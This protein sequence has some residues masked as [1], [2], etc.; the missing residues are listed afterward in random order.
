MWFCDNKK[1]KSAEMDLQNQ[2]DALKK[3]N[4]SL[5]Y[6]ND[7]YKSRLETEMNSASFVIDW[8]TMNVFSVERMWSNGLHKTII[9]YLLAEPVIYTESDDQRVTHKD[10]VREWSLYCSAEMHEKLANEFK[11]YLEEK[12]CSK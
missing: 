7:A 12:K 1:R 6:S 4:E 8:K 9:G 5:K 2:L 3:E 11:E 10:V